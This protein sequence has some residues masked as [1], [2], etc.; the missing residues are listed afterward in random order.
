MNHLQI[1]IY[2]KIEKY[3]V[4]FCRYSGVYKSVHA[5]KTKYICMKN[6]NVKTT[7]KKF[8]YRKNDAHVKGF[9]TYVSSCK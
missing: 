5:C 6:K 2:T 4:F 1:E 3:N 8:V 9:L 7:C